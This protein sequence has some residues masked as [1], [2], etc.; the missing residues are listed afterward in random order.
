PYPIDRSEANPLPL[1]ELE[2]PIRIG[3]TSSSWTISPRLSLIG[4]TAECQLALADD[5]ISR[6]HASLI[7]TPR[8]M[9]VIDLL[10]REGVWVNGTRVRWA[11]LDDGDALRIGRFTFVLRYRFLPDQIA[12][13]D[14]PLDAGAIFSPSSARARNSSGGLP[15]ELARSLA[16]RSH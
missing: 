1:A 16:S 2:L 11:W 7:R 14:V 4:R 15:A 13:G 8:G 3:E 12:R 10:S 9:W 5:S 6:Y